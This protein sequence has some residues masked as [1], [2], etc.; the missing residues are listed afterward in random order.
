MKKKLRYALFLMLLLSSLSASAWEGMAMPRLH[1]D[2]KYFKD[3]QG[4]IVNLH[5]FAQTYSPWFNEKGTK[6][7][8]Y[9]ESGCLTYNQGL[10]DK[11]LAAGWK[12]NFMRLHMDPY[13][14][15]D[16]TKTA[17]G[18]SDI[19]AFSYARFTKY[20]KR[21]F[22]PMAKYAISKGLYVIMRP[23]GVCPDS[24][25]I[26]DA[27][28]KYLIQVW[29]YVSSYP[30][31]KNN[32]NIM[33]EL[34]N[35][36]VGIY[37]S[38]KSVGSYEDL[39][40]YFQ[41]VVD[42]I[43]KNCDNIVLVPGTGYQADYRAY[44]QYPISGDNV[45]YAVHCYPGWMNSGSES[46]PTVT[47]TQFK[48]GWDEQ[49]KPV[50]DNAP[51]VVTE[52][53]WAPA[54]YNSSWGK[55]TTGT[56]GGTGFGANFKKIADDSGNVSWLIFTEA[57][58]MAQYDDT[59]SDGST[60]LTDPQACPRPAY[61]W[62]QTYATTQ[63][64]HQEY[65]Y[66]STSDQGD[67]TY[68]NPVIQGD[69]PDPDVIKVGDTYYMVSTTMHNFPGC[70]LLKSK[71][72]V[73]WEFCCNPLTKMSSYP[74]YNLEDGKNIYAKGSWANSLMYKNGKFY[75][76]FNAFGNSDDGGGYLLSATDPE[77]TWT[78]TRLSQG[79]YDPGMLLD[80]DGTVYVACG[81]T[82]ISVVQLDDN[83]AKVKEST[84][85]SDFSGLEGNHF[86]KKDGY[87]YIYS[88]YAAWPAQQWCFR[89]KSVFGP[90]EK[91]KVF[92]SDDIHQGS[93]IQTQSGEWWTM[94]MRDCGAF[95]RMPYLEPVTWSSDWPV[96]GVNGKDATVSSA[97]TKPN[98]NAS[99]APKAL[100]TNDNFLNYKLGMQWQ[101]NH[102]ADNSKWSLMERAGY[103]R[104]YTANVT[105]SLQ[106]A[107]NTLTQRIFGFHDDTKKSYGTIR[108]NVSKMQTGDMAGL[109][110]FQE[111]YAFIGVKKV[112]GNQFELSVQSNSSSFTMK[113]KTITCDSVIYL[114]AIADIATSKAQF[115]YCLD[116]NKTYNQYGSTLDMKYDLKIFV[117][118]RFCIFNY[119]TQSLGGYVD[120][121]WFST[122]PT[123]DE[124]TY[125][126]NTFTA[127][128]ADYLT[129]TSMSVG[130][131]AI[132]M[133]TGASK[134][135]TLTATFADGH[136]ADITS[137]ATYSVGNTNVVTVKNGR[138]TAAGTG[139][140]TVTVT[141]KDPLGSTLTT[142]FTVTSSMFPLTADLLNPS[143]YATGTFD[144]T[145]KTLVTG[146]YGFGGWQYSNGIDIS[147]YKYI[148]VKLNKT[149]TGG[150]QFRM[151][152]ENN[153][154]SKCSCTTLSKTTSIL[155]SSLVKD[156]T[157]TSLNLSHIYIAG[158]WANSGTVSIKEIFLSNDGLTPIDTG[159]E[160]PVISSP[161][162]LIDIYNLS[163]ML[164]Y[165]KVRRADV[166]TLLKKGVYIVD[167]KCVIV[168]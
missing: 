114:R 117:G 12:V 25:K 1:V 163:G 103:L 92:D 32:P 118:N 52:M 38:D 35:E 133:L 166:T 94:L 50:S 46:T 16:P 124:S 11:I 128:S 102:N 34:A 158:F 82:N 129:A 57:Y 68:K 109:A 28:Q 152:D 126:D 101:W 81:N 48:A 30:D 140:T 31:I 20:F 131:S 136:T 66:Q 7:T 106:K 108:M 90:Y 51:I 84:V 14:S 139:T 42:S 97:Y 167:H 13:W 64:P 165:S 123:F 154:W 145:T 24:I 47:Y 146:T 144:E 135:F 65:T 78:M 49:I 95:G 53:D 37:K 111:P 156:G 127:Y 98:V 137:D 36:P 80:D 134:T 115:Y 40:D 130:S 54:T 6:W 17:T 113:K 89:S 138:L 55:G 142:S 121:D 107:R 18:E 73:N 87:Y 29:D 45:G 141:Y 168:K 160:T 147:Q 83:F 63:Y 5:G 71:D 150:A 74:E 59:A 19:S 149:P 76:M 164:L 56:E 43:R 27:Y 116:D 3:A 151:F 120:V 125:Y 69:F 85:I 105:D 119:A 26:G 62:Y 148:V 75:I 100:P 70:T 93:M 104:L 9:D 4:N 39:H 159:I 33:F 22:L 112:S 88:T 153:Y 41:T 155:L 2:G 122:E 21:V 67:G 86:F 132:N 10:I 143:I 162:D 96:I 72:L 61:R 23:P 99:Y 79:Y 161:D 44:G 15:N 77:G 58:L 110:V 60:F 8:N 157:T 91:Q